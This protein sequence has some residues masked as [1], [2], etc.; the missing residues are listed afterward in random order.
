ML[1]TVTKDH[2]K[3]GSTCSNERCP[4]A[5]ALAEMFPDL[6]PSV[7]HRTVVLTG[8]DTLEYYETSPAARKFIEDFDLDESVVPGTF[9]L[10]LLNGEAQ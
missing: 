1:V 5:L 7:R 10:T 8:I 4:I 6:H 2:I 9:E 3:N